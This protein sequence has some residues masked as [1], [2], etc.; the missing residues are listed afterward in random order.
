MIKNTIRDICEWIED[1]F[2]FILMVS[3]SLL[4]L[5]GCAMG[6]MI[7]IPLFITSLFW[8][9]ICVFFL[10]IMLVIITIQLWIGVFDL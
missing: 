5:A 4:V 8:V 1:I 2:L 10:V 7:T 9:P 3:L 6:I